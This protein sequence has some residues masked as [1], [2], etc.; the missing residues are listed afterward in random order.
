MR[1]CFRPETAC[2]DGVDN[3]GDGV[4]DCGDPD[5]DNRTCYSGQTCTMRMCPGPG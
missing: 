5:C 2:D 1:G 3:D 4:A